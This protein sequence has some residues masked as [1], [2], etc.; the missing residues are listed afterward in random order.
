MAIQ[1][2]DLYQILCTVPFEYID[3]GKDHIRFDLTYSRPVFK[4]HLTLHSKRV[5][6]S[7]AYFHLFSSFDSHGRMVEVHFS[8][9]QRSW[10]YDAP[11]EKLHDVYRAQKTFNNLLRNP[12]NFFEIKMQ[13]GKTLNL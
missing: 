12:E 2:P 8:N 1:F 7:M 11:I 6:I 13:P 5:K 4:Y 9:Q 10:F 3:D